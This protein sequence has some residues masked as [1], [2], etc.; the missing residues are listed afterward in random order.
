MPG[1]KELMAMVQGGGQ[2]QMDPKQQMMLKVLQQM[3]SKQ[4]QP[5]LSEE[6]EDYGIRQ[7]WEGMPGKPTSNDIEYGNSEGDPGGGPSP[8]YGAFAE[9]H[10]VSPDDEDMLDMIS[11]KMG[12]PESDTGSVAE[13]GEY[14][15]G[16]RTDDERR[17]F[18][19]RMHNRRQGK[20]PLEGFVDELDVPR[21]DSRPGEDDD[22]D[23]KMAPWEN[24]A[25]SDDEVPTKED[26]AYLNAHGS[27]G[28]IGSFYDT[29][30]TWAQEHQLMGNKIKR[31]NSKETYQYGPDPY[32]DVDEPWEDDD[33]R[34]LNKNRRTR[35]DE[36]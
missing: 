7:A 30:R 3:Q 36:R 35:I 13:E 24:R 32:A 26:I 28:V 9:R 18:S 22:D 21:K 29:F 15:E 10:G 27:D 31:K 14:E 34:P 1:I 11:A 25:E 2:S 6:E 5:E 16:G 12:A 17:D 33:G 4:Q 23:D 20:H 19:K 8:I